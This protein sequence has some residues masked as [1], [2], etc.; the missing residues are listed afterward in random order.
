VNALPSNSAPFFSNVHTVSN[1]QGLSRPCAIRP[2]S[3]ARSRQSVAWLIAFFVSAFCGLCR[4]VAEEPKPATPDEKQLAKQALEISRREA[5][6][7]ELEL[8]REQ[9]KKLKLNPEP[10]LRWSNPAVGE[11]YG[12]VFVWTSDGRPEAVASIYK[13]YSPF[14]HYSTEFQSFSETGLVGSYDGRATWTPARAGLEF[15]PV[16][17][18]PPPAETAAGRLRQMRDMASGFTAAKT[19]REGQQQ[20]LRL[21]TQPVY[22]YES[23]STAVADGGLFTFVEGTD[24]EVFLLLEARRQAEGVRWQYALTRMNSTKFEA[25]Y[26]EKPVWSVDILPWSQVRDHAEPYTTFQYQSAE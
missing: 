9:P 20:K 25:S 14:K 8:A 18:G 22:R 11:I 5:G 7:W 17:A 16:P 1:M 10:V 23:A 4:A 15:K 26:Q 2:G 13:W 6:R 3:A 21:L 24:P 12:A 19:D